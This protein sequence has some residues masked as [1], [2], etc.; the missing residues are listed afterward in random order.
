MATTEKSTLIK[1]VNIFDGTSSQ[2]ISD[3]DVV[4]LG[5]KIRELVASGGNDASY[6]AVIDGGGGTLMPGL[7]AVHTHLALC[8]PPAE[9]LNV[10]RW[11]Y[12]G[13][14]MTN[15]AERYLMRGFTSVRD[16]G[17]PTLG[18]KLAIDELRSAVAAVSDGQLDTAIREPVVDELGDI[19]RGFNRMTHELRDTMVSRDRLQGIVDERTAALQE[20]ANQDHLTGV[21][22]RRRPLAARI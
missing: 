4:L 1:N 10:R 14:V 21:A 15:E 6:D 12:I 13:A 2:L 18:L 20:L 11:D 9:L 7:S 3:N 17:G 16:V 22:N 8:R 19:A 5:N